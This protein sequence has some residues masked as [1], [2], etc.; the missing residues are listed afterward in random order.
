MV[1]IYNIFLRLYILAIQLVAW[2]NAKAKQMLQG[3]QGLLQKIKQYQKA[4]AQTIWM[5]CA[6][7]GEYE[8]GLPVLQLLKK[9]YP[10]C[11]VVLTFF[12][13]SGYTAWRPMEA[14]DEM[15]YLPFD[16][17]KNAIEFIDC[18]QPTMVIFVK[19]EL[20]YHY[21]HQLYARKINTYMISMHVQEASVFVKWYGKLHV[22]M[23]SY[24]TTIFVQNQQSKLRLQ[25]L[26]ISNQIA[27]D[28]RF[29]RMAAIAQ[30]PFTDAKIAAFCTNQ[31]ILIAG[32]TWP[33]DES[34]LL[35]WIMLQNLGFKLVIVPHEL[36]AKH[37]LQIKT[38]FAGQI[39][40]YTD[41][42]INADAKVF[43]VN[44][45]GMLKH[46]YSYATMAYIGGGFGSG[47]HNILEPLSYAIPVIHGPNCS[48]FAE[49][50]TF[51]DIGATAIIKNAQDLANEVLHFSKNK[52][53][54]C[55]KI[56]TLLQQ[57]RGAS[58]TIVSQLQWTTTTN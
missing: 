24:F 43:L 42:Q 50:A 9:Q 2:R 41:A 55:P 53:I 44:K 25:Q 20:W 16:T 1:F 45:M 48:R 8:Q 22:K 14:V 5:H 51:Y 10:T 39:T 17:K 58:S 56:T 11:R 31:N 26:G 36:D 3:R 19:Y 28:T 49:A 34:I 21:L 35:Q 40:C 4:N 37:I 18:I 38:I 57:N 29:D 6:S 46:I 23:L 7:V 33:Q 32:S 12:S 47:I 13:A 15:Y 54:I 27:G 52:D 30:L